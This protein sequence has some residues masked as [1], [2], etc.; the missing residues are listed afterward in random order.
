MPQTTLPVD[1]PPLDGREGAVQALA[2]QRARGGCTGDCQRGARE[3]TGG[4]KLAAVAAPKAVS[5]PVDTSPTVVKF[6]ALAVLLMVS[7][8]PVIPVAELSR[9]TPAA[10]VMLSELLTRPLWTTAWPAGGLAG[11]HGL[12]HAWTGSPRRATWAATSCCATT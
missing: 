6:L 4:A 3:R 2:V 9:S 7:V 5:V 8:L 11:P 10:P 12:D 1:T